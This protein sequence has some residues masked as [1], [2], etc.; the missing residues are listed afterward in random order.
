MQWATG[1][2]IGR[3]CWEYWKH[4]SLLGCDVMDN[5]YLENIVLLSY[6]YPYDTMSPHT[7]S[8][9]YLSFC[10]TYIIA[11]QWQ[12][13]LPRIW[14]KTCVYMPKECIYDISR[15]VHSIERVNDC[16][17]MSNERFFSAIQSS[18]SMWSLLLSSRLY[19]WDHFFFVL[20]VTS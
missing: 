20:K 7:C 8:Y 13:P 12:R 16:S 17:L 19:L 15:H 2:S 11:E 4:G 1:I 5:L 6:S 3:M 14:L 10:Y 18:L 9:S